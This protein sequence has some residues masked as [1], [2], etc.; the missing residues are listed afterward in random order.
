MG[1]A[2]ISDFGYLGG[3]GMYIGCAW[4]D[5]RGWFFCWGVF[6]GICRKCLLIRV[7]WR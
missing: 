1:E 4:D 5:R 3:H 6:G 7:M 2:V